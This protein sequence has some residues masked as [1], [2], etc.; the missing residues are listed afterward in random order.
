LSHTG[1]TFFPYLLFSKISWQH[2]R[3]FYQYFSYIV[4]TYFVCYGKP[5]CLEENNWSMASDWQTVSNNVVSST[6]L[7]PHKFR[8][9]IGLGLCLKPLSTIFQLY[10]GGQYYWW[11]IPGLGRFMVF[12]GEYQRRSSLSIHKA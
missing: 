9:E 1:P 6:P 12:N 11:R 4:D 2:P 5:D 8:I 3:D 7:T 10:R